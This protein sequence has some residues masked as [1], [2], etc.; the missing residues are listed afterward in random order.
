MTA[1]AYQAVAVR[2]V[3]RN[4]SV[5]TK[6]METHLIPCHWK[7]TRACLCQEY[8]QTAASAEGL[9]LQLL[10]VVEACF[11]LHIRRK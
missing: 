1:T 6:L 2:G 5:Q 10:E 3:N 9:V 7:R 11:R 4:H 8:N